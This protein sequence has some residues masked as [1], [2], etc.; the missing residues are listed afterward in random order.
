MGVL[1]MIPLML[2]IFLYILL[3]VEDFDIVEWI[4]NF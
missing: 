4:Y 3:V 1:S 2:I